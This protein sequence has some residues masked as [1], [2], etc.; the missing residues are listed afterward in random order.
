MVGVVPQRGWPSRLGPT[1]VS[2]EEWSADHVSWFLET[3]GFPEVAA[4]AER[5]RVNGATLLYMNNEAWQ[6]WL[7]CM[8]RGSE[9]CLRDP[10]SP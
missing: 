6:V 2:V 10:C 8:R 3:E 1:R 7:V 9:K 5:Q 4:A